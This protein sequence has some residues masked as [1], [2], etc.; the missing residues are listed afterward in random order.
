MLARR[1]DDLVAADMG[2]V[3][4][5]EHWPD[6]ALDDGVTAGG[7]HLVAWHVE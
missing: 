2:K 5:D 6:G 1:A 3:F 4:E 7:A